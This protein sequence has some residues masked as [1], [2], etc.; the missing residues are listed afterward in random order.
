MIQIDKNILVVIALFLL[1]VKYLIDQLFNRR[2]LCN[3]NNSFF[4]INYKINLF[5]MINSRKEQHNLQYIS[6]YSNRSS[7]I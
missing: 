1:R 3:K 6:N 2:N 5:Q 7:V 4:S